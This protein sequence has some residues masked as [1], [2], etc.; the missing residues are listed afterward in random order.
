MVVFLAANGKKVHQ[1]PQRALVS[2]GY[3][4]H[5]AER[6][7]KVQLF[8]PRDARQF[9]ADCTRLGNGK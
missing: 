3:L 1:V 4:M 9:E 7:C 2:D 8:E 5:Y 6:F